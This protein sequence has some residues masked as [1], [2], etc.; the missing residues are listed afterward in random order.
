LIELAGFVLI[1]PGSEWFWTAISGIV[2]AITFIAI[3]RQ[4][5]L[6]RSAS[7]FEQVDRL[8]KDW[9]SELAARHRLAILEAIAAGTSLDRLPSGSTSFIAAFWE[10]LAALVRAGHV[11]PRTVHDSFGPAIRYW[12]VILGPS[13]AAYRAEM[14]VRVMEHFD[15]LVARM[16]AMDRAEHRPF[17]IDDAYIADTLESRIT[18]LRDEL[19]QAEAVRTI[20]IT[21]MPAAMVAPASEVAQRRAPSTEPRR[22][23]RP[24]TPATN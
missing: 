23:S 3:Y 21:S 12:S 9:G 5:A 17:H 18:A 15:W 14:K 13:T 16:T 7:A 11:D 6:A 10:D 8:S 22:R 1:G 20:V 24:R 19:R 2:L 4:L